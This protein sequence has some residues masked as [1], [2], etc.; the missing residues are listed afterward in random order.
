MEKEKLGLP[1][2]W[3]PQYLIDKDTWMKDYF[4]PNDKTGRR[5]RRTYFSGPMSV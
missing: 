5:V 2:N 3:T 4:S 1:Q